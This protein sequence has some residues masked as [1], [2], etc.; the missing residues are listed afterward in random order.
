MPLSSKKNVDI[1]VTKDEHLDARECKLE[2]CS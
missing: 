1:N 2:H